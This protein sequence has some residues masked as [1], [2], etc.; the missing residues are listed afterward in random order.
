MHIIEES[1]LQTFSHS[2]NYFLPLKNIHTC[3]A[4]LDIPENTAFITM[5]I[6]CILIELFYEMKNGYDESHEGGTVGNAYKEILPLLDPTISEDL[7]ILFYKGIRCGILHQGQTKNNTAL[8]YQLDTIIQPNGPYYLCN[9]QTLFEKLK[10]LY[11][12]YWKDISEKNYSDELAINLI[13]KYNY[14]LTHIS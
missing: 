12:L 10:N 8:T 7:A 13:Q 6:N 4:K 14:I 5:G 11:R 9:P 1:Y 3:L 2:L